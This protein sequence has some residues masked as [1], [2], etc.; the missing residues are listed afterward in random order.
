MKNFVLIFDQIRPFITFFQ[1]V[2]YIPFAVE[3]K[4]FSMTFF[5]FTF[6][7]KRI[8]VWWFMLQLILQLVYGGFLLL[9]ISNPI[10]E[11][12]ILNDKEFPLT[13]IFFILTTY[14]A[15]GFQFI[16]ARLIL[17]NYKRFGNAVKIIQEIERILRKN[18][19]CSLRLN[20]IVT[21]RFVLSFTSVLIM[22][23][24]ARKKPRL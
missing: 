11:D 2:G 19:A 17:L 16:I 12:L 15:Y 6:S 18:G 22:V 24:V 5:R 4:P 13:L 8:V 9:S 23:T 10:A 1:S 21:K 20:N 7:L 3:K 14:V